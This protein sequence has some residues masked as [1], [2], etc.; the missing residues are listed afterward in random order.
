MKKTIQL[1][2]T[3]TEGQNGEC[4][5]TFV[6]NGDGTQDDVLRILRNAIYGA[7]KVYERRLEGIASKIIGNATQLN[8]PDPAFRLTAHESEPRR[9]SGPS[10]GRRRRRR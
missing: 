3:E 4:N 1:I 8:L 7:E 5:L 6:Q 9:L 2:L 10:T